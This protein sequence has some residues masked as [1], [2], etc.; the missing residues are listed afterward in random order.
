MQKRPC[1]HSPADKVQHSF[2][3]HFPTPPKALALAVSGG[4]DSLALTV[5]AREWAKEHGVRLAVL[6]VDHGLRPE[7]K[8]EAD[9]VAAICADWGIEHTTLI[10]T[11]H[12]QTGNLMAEARVARYRLMA[13]WAR[14]NG[15]SQIALGHTSDDNA[16]TFVMGLMRGAGLDGL[17]GMRPTFEAH[18]VHFERPLLRC[19][20]AALR[21]LLAERGLSWVEDPSN[22]DDQYDRVRVRKALASLEGLSL[23]FD[24][25]IANLRATRVDLMEELWTRIETEI[26]VTPIDLA[27]SEAVFLTLTSELRRRFLNCAIRFISGNDYPPRADKV[28]RI[29]SGGYTEAATLGGVLIYLLNGKIRVTREPRKAQ[30]PVPVGTLWDERF[31][32]QGPDHAAVVAA[33]GEKG[34]RQIGAIWRETGASRRSLLASPAVWSGE[35]V[36]FA[37]YAGVLSSE[38][39]VNCLLDHESFRAFVLTH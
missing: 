37:P 2:D 8:Q 31:I 38:W 4:S 5:L 19:K 30:G 12:P 28:Q 27:L 1:G 21:L 22:D 10:W 24:K 14:E 9:Q 25:S 15:I 39:S 34:L 29:C 26:E 7:A 13:E 17:S 6:T 3:I 18:G 23:D 36:V 33:L 32:V 35:N 20:R 16:E 11:D